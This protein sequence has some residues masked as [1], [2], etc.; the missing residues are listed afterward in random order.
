MILKEIACRNRITELKD[1]FHHANFITYDFCNDLPTFVDILLEIG[2]ND[3]YR[4]NNTLF[5]IYA[6]A[7]FINIGN[8]IFLISLN[9]ITQYLFGIRSFLSSITLITGI[10]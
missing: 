10:L 5:Y 6:V 9:L 4:Y 3:T 2:F 7:E 1:N 8:A